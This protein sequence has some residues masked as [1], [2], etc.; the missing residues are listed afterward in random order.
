MPGHVVLLWSVD[1]ILDYIDGLELHDE[2]LGRYSNELGS[3]GYLSTGLSYLNAQVRN[4][5]TEVLSRVPQ[6]ES[7]F[8]F[9]KGPPLGGAPQELVAC[10]F[11]WYSVTACNYVRLVGWLGS[12]GD[13]REARAYLKRV[14][15]EVTRWRNKVGAHFAQTDPRRDDSPAD[16]AASIMF[17]ISFDEDAFYAGSLT[18]TLG[19]SSQAGGEATEIPNWRRRLLG[20]LGVKGSRSRT[21]MRWSLSNTHRQLASRYWPDQLNHP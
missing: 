18:L 3:L 7:V 11:H 1:V 9:G 19:T 5:E 21:D 13:D 2:D 10:A 20:G 6:N 12:G 8:V 16:L 4:A 17:P 14:L 15:P